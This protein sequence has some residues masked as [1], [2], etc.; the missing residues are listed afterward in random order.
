MKQKIFI[1]GLVTA[2]IILAGTMFKV[3]HYPGAGILL[4]LGIFTLIM[5][6][7]PV[8][9]LNHYK[10]EGNKQ[11]I[12]LYFVTWLTCFVLFTAMLFKIMHWPGAGY[13]LLFS[14]PFPFVVFLPVFLIVTSKIKNFNIY[15]TVYILLLLASISV[16]SALLAVGVSREKIMDS[17]EIADN[18]NKLEKAFEEIPVIANSESAK[19]I[20]LK[21]DALL[22]LI[23]DCQSQLLKA[24]GSS[25]EQWNNDPKTLS[26]PDSKQI[27]Q[28]VMLNGN[29]PQ[30]ANRLEGEL[31]SL[32]QELENTPEY[33]GMAKVTPVLFDFREPTESELPWAYRLFG[34]NYLSWVMIYLDALE[35]NLYYIRASVN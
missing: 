33:S 14:L 2:L 21:I 3:N 4:T 5:I 27:A 20:D 23:N 34:D 7:L 16:F 8:A 28:R 15:N 17:L 13:L 31:K 22:R 35:V 12:S 26:Y 1:L 11:N 30:L 29:E 10:S 24:S 25:V 18:Y 9:L 19:K 6:F 32:L